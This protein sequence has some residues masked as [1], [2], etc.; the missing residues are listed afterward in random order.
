[1]S[2][3]PAFPLA[4][5]RVLDLS[6]EI[7]GPYAT[8]LLVDAGA[9][10][11]KVEGPGG[12][13]LRRFSSSGQ[14]LSER[15]GALFQ[16]LNGGK[17]SVDWD[18]E[19]EAGRAAFLRL[20]QTADL[21]VESGGAGWLE[22]RGLDFA[23]LR[24]RNP[25]VSLVS[26]SPY[27]RTGP[28]A[29]RP[30]TDFT[31]Q[32]EVGS[33]AY[34][35][36][37]ERGPVY[38]PG[39]LGEYSAGAAVAVGALATWRSAR[40]SGVGLHADVSMLEA[41][42]LCFTTYHDLF[43]QFVPGF[44]IPIAVE[45]PSIEPCKDGWIGL[46]TYT[47]Q[48]WKDLCALMGRPDVGEDK[49]F[50]DGSARMQHLDFILDV[51]RGWTKTQTMAEVAEL[52]GLMR[53]PVA[54]IG[55]GRSVLE[56]D[57]F[58]E[59]G[60]FLDHPDGFK[61]PRPPYRVHGMAMP[62][63]RK[64]PRLGADRAEIEATLPEAAASDAAIDAS[65]VRPAFDG[66]RVIDLTAFWA[67][68]L[69]TGILA[70]LGADVVKIESIQRPD[71]MRFAGAIPSDALWETSPIF[72]GANPS[73][74][75]VTLN[76][77]AEEGKAILR[78]LLADADVVIENFSA[79]VMENFGFT[80]DVL[81]ALNPKLIS[82]RMPA[83]GLDGPWK[84]RTGF[85][86]NVEQ[87][88]GLAWIT[89]YED[90]P[91][92]PRGV[93][94]PVGGMHTVFAL[95]MGLEERARTG[96][97]TVVEVP[98][99]EPALNMAAEQVIEWTAYGA[100]LGRR[101]NRGPVAS[102]QAVFPTRPSATETRF[103]KRHV[104]LAIET[105][106]QWGALVEAL[107]RPDWAADARY[108]TEVGRRAGEE[109]IEAALAAW[110]A[111]QDCDAVVERLVGEGVPAA[112]LVNG[113]L[114]SPHPQLE[115]RG[116]RRPLTHAVTGEMRYAGLPF[117]LSNEAANVYAWAAPTLGQHNRD[118]LQGELGLSDEAFAALEAAQVIGTRPAFDL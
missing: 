117:T 92:I 6:T 21:V 70:T 114:I 80:W 56:F 104:A 84:D 78:R 67:G 94:D 24:A 82:V 18:L 46:C 51:I 14:D 63:L 77:D 25:A 118:V 100:F 83:W 45:T 81:H 112:T 58:R 115:A 36:L 10:V 90:M 41:L 43:G 29:T 28:W 54:P 108:A 42:C 66:L 5:V 69:A 19:T 53:I 2:E 68:P 26:V 34:R 76:L 59:R 75:G 109:A 22:A 31:L 106:A 47:G 38:A 111:D 16:F 99:V 87:A 79:R 74:K 73:K 64:A 86:P 3:A 32:A 37:P 102:P 110:F 97:G 20:V 103:E 48:Q 9:E 105:D 61:A 107:G 57:Q 65:R 27:G 95:A 49:R 85:A 35:G 62:A 15:D 55:D 89:G 11:I 60:V 1:M 7:A 91:L 4:G 93:C 113:Y 44:A 33:T 101:G 8:K 72:H 71:G 116:F 98:L 88:S 50:Y 96:K 39:R 30:A 12:D 13:P 23:T 40:A 17:R 52:A